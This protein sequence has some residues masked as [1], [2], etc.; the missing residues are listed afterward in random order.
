VS[1][2]DLFPELNRLDEQR[3]EKFN[4]LLVTGVILVPRGSI[5]ISEARLRNLQDYLNQAR[6]EYVMAGVEAK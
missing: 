2:P 6:F 5:L 3:W 4:T 1:D